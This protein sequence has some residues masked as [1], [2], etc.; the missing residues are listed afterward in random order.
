MKC[1]K[2]GGVLSEYEGIFVCEGCGAR[3]KKKATQSEQK[4][5]EQDNQNT[6]TEAEVQPETKR[7]REKSELELLKARLAEME[8]RQSEMEGNG[9]RRNVDMK[10]KLARFKEIQFFAFLKKWGLKVVL[11]CTLVLIVFIS[12]MVCLVGVRGVYYNVDNPNEFYEFTATKYIYHGTIDGLYEYETEGSWKTRNG[13]LY[14]SYKDELFGKQTDEYYFSK[15][16]DKEIYIGED[17]EELSTFKRAGLGALKVISKKKIKVKFDSAGGDFCETK[18]LAKGST[19][20]KPENEP[21]R[22][23]YQFRGWYQTQ[24]GYKTKGEKPFQEDSRIWES[25]TYYANWWSERTFIVTVLGTD[26]SLELEEGDNLLSKL[27]ETE[28][29]DAYTYFIDG[30]QITEDMF[31]P[32]EDIQITRHQ[33]A[34]TS[35]KIIFDANG[36]SIGWDSTKEIAITIGQE[37]PVARRNGFLFV[38]WRLPNGIITDDRDASWGYNPDVWNVD[39]GAVFIAEWIKWNDRL[40]AMTLIEDFCYYVDNEKVYIT[41]FKNLDTE[42]LRIPNGVFAIR[43]QANLSAKNGVGIK[44]LYIPNS[45][46]E[47]NTKKIFV[48]ADSVWEN[49]TIHYDGTVDEWLAFGKWTRRIKVICSDGTING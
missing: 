15:K 5:E 33:S 32:A 16:S 49:T 8:K 42:S 47:V 2:C 24:Y 44:N 14:L 45:I 12:L 22:E 34:T 36:G 39:E 11:P 9:G 25:V 30:H 10:E 20:Q 37:M 31:M 7:E 35:K 40:S 18:V 1:P 26:I 4:Q 19:T 21:K 28:N 41:A 3:F 13:K 43:D 38:G 23:G 48:E 17:K 27:K 6:T 29:G 46:K